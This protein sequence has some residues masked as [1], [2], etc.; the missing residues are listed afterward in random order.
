MF[1]MW[2]SDAQNW[3]TGDFQGED[4]FGI[5]STIDR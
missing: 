5:A 3:N 4:Q 2:V 1:S